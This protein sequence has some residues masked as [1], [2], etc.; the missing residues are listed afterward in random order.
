MF[1]WHFSRKDGD[2]RPAVL[3][4]PDHPPH[5]PTILECGAFLE[6]R[7]ATK[8]FGQVA[9]AVVFVEGDIFWGRETIRLMIF[10][11]DLY[12]KQKRN[13]IKLH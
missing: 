8:Y 2:F 5:H 11:R 12:K 13:F 3:G 1:S 10:Q 4:L 7:G 6:R 9:A